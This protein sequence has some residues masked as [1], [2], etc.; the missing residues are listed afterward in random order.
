MKV[1]FYK[2][3]V[4]VGGRRWVLLVLT[5]LFT[6]ALM[7]GTRAAFGSVTHSGFI[8]TSAWCGLS[9][10][11]GSAIAQVVARLTITNTE[12]SRA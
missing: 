3:A 7:W 1:S 12:G 4:L 2:K 6:A 11:T 5:G 10:L 9:G 8:A